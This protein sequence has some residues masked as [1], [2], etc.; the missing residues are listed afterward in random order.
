MQFQDKEVTLQMNADVF[1]YG[2]TRTHD[3]FDMYLPE[4]L[5]SYT[6]EY[7]EY[8]KTVSF[9]MKIRDVLPE[10]R[11]NVLENTAD[12]FMF[13]SGR[14]I[15]MLCRFCHICGED[16]F[17]RPICS[18][19]GFVVKS[20]D[21]EDLRKIIPDALAMMSGASRTCY[22]QYISDYGWEAKPDPVSLKA[23]I[24]PGKYVFPQ[25]E[26]FRT[27]KASLERTSRTFS[28][29]CG[30]QQKSLYDYS[31]END[32]VKINVFFAE[33]E[34]TEIP[35]DPEPENTGADFGTLV[36]Y[37][38]ITKTT[39]GRL[40]YRFMLCRPDNSPG[41]GSIA[42]E[43]YERETG[44]EIKLEE[45]FRMY[46]SVCE[47]LARNGTDE[48]SRRKAVPYGSEL[49]AEFSGK[50]LILEYHPPKEQKRSFMQII[51]GE[52]LPDFTEYIFLR[53]GE[54]ERKLSDITPAV[55]LSDDRASV[56]FLYSE[57]MEVT[58]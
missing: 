44:S 17:G 42:Y 41:T 45:L 48:K 10:D 51:K 5:E 32:E 21:T 26:W 8:R 16:E 34:C 22:D 31:S 33:D 30:D 43:S 39:E 20:S 18:T 57:L 37:A 28:F 52:K 12:S 53:E 50:K 35:A 7:R 1:L 11:V 55:K 58:L 9:I 15:S 23:D 36:P 29:V 54:E 47:Y 3:Y 25:K 24:V 40:K 27:M 6:E 19:E 38:G 13:I 56:M 4:W 2:R 49:T 14:R 46:Q